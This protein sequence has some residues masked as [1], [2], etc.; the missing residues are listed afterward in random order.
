MFLFT[1]LN[2]DIDELA[3]L[4]ACLLLRMGRRV[5]REVASPRIS[6]RVTPPTNRC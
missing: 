4:C 5:L 1:Y 2:S 3:H 6:E